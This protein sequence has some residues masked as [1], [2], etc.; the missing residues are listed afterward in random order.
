MPGTCRLAMLPAMA[1]A[2]QHFRHHRRGGQLQDSGIGP[3][4]VVGLV[5]TGLVAVAVGVAVLLLIVVAASP[6][7]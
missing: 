2:H 1:I 5:R 6:V 7:G 3:E 4:L